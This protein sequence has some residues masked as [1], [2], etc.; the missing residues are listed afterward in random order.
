MAQHIKLLIDNTANLAAPSRSTGDREKLFQRLLSVPSSFS[1]DEFKEALALLGKRIDF[2]TF[3][4]LFIERLKS[5]PDANSLVNRSI[6][7]ILEDSEE[8]EVLLTKLERINAIGLFQVPA[9][10]PAP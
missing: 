1:E 2:E 3:N 8:C 4:A 6:L 9:L 5:R 7:A 10:Q